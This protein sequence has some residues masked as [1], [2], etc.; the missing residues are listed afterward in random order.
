MWK[1][2]FKQAQFVAIKSSY[3]AYWKEWNEIENTITRNSRNSLST[4]QNEIFDAKR[5]QT[6]SIEG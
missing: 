6:R 1:S 4:L 2:K 3:L 5:Y